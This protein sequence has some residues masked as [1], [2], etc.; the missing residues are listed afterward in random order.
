MTLLPGAFRDSCNIMAK[1]RINGQVHYLDGTP[2]EDARVVIIERDSLPGGKDDR[3]LE[4]LTD[5]EGKFS[6][7]SKEWRDR[8]GVGGVPGAFE[9]DLPDIF[10]LDF[11]VKAGNT[12]H[13]GPFVLWGNQSAPIVLPVFPPEPVTKAERELVQIIHLSDGY[14]GPER[15]LY[16]FI[17][18]STETLTGSILG[19]SYRKTAFLKG[20]DATLPKFV[21]ALQAAAAR[22]QTEAVDVIFTTH[23][24]SEKVYF[25]DGARPDTEVRDAVLKVPASQ[26]RKLRMLFSTACIG[27]THL[28]A[29]LAAGFNEASGA[30]GIYAD[31]AV[32]YAPFL[33]AWALK[34]T[35]AESVDVANN[36]DVGDT[37]DN[38][39]RTY[40]MA[41]GMDTNASR[42]DSHRVRAGTGRSRIYTTP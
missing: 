19:N 17:E 13:E 42:V 36:A 2:A 15:A 16:E 38:I 39:A 27:A 25:A 10:R 41:R 24:A 3:I 20:A 7:L 23:G 14:T 35:F 29:W 12:A 1:L 9:F 31:S 22:Q 40:Y 32:S 30:R 28:D 37:A 26:R 21:A 11:T 4:C 34:K 5:A 6:G 18:N 8:E 33:G